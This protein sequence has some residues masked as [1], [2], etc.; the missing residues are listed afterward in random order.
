MNEEE[1]RGDGKVVEEAREEVVTSVEAV[2]DEDELR[3]VG[4]DETLDSS[5]LSLS[6]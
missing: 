4:R 5:D 3:E 2:E 1:A 6:V